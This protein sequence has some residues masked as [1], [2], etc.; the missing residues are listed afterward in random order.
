MPTFSYTWPSETDGEPAEVRA[1]TVALLERIVAEAVMIAEDAQV[2]LRSAGLSEAIEHGATD[3]Q[4]GYRLRRPKEERLVD[5][6]AIHAQ[7]FE[8]YVRVLAKA[9]RE[10][11]A[12]PDASIELR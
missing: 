3:P 1:R 5:Q 4:E 2:Q 6:L 11:D 7:Q 9:S 10:Y 8:R 12:D